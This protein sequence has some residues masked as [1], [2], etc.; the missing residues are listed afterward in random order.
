MPAVSQ[1]AIAIETRENDAEVEMLMAKVNHSDTWNAIT[2]ERA[3]LARL[4]GGCQVPLGCYSK[5]EKELLV[6][7]GFVASIDGKQYIKETISGNIAKGAELGVEMAE[8][9]LGRGAHEILNQ[10]KT[11]NNIH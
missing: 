7:S 11:I 3:F 1:G 8:K 6:L 4:E 2:A 5:V 9:M 10:I